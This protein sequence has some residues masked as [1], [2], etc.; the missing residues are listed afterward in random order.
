[1]NDQLPQLVIGLLPWSRDHKNHFKTRVTHIFERMGRRYGWERV[2]ECLDDKYLLVAAAGGGP[3]GGDG[4]EV[5]GEEGPGSGV[6]RDV[7]EEG[8][9]VVLAIRKKKERAKKKK[10]NA[11]ENEGDDEVRSWISDD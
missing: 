6:G 5:E 3:K 9:K 8:K 7:L 1:V 10:R 11:K 4:M 2:L